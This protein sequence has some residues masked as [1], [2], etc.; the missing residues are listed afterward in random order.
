M[1]K[2]PQSWSWWEHSKSANKSSRAGGTFQLLT[3]WSFSLAGLTSLSTPFLSAFPHRL[4][5]CS[6]G[7][8]QVHMG[9]LPLR[10]EPTQTHT[11]R[12][13]LFGFIT[14]PQEGSHKHLK[15]LCEKPSAH[16]R[17]GPNPTPTQEATVLSPG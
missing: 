5:V 6:N 1:S 2:I 8:T 7:R 16:G 13:P 14:N 15:D 12:P 17:E 9:F 4:L 10:S 3:A 11:L